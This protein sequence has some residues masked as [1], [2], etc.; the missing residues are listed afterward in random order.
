MESVYVPIHSTTHSEASNVN[1][2]DMGTLAQ[3]SDADLLVHYSFGDGN[4][5]WCQ[6]VSGLKSTYCVNR[7][8][9]GITYGVYS[10]ANRTDKSYGWRPILT[11]LD[12][13]K[14]HLK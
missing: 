8:T 3:Y 11:K 10:I 12:L 9:F 6:E 13:N 5:S 4:Y 7:G 2:S 1:T 14:K